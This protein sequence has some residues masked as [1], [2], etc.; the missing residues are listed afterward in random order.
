MIHAPCH[1]TASLL[2]NLYRK[3]VSVYHIYLSQYLRV[4][5]FRIRIYEDFYVHYSIAVE[6]FRVPVFPTR[7]FRLP[8]QGTGQRHQKATFARVQGEAPAPH[9]VRQHADSLVD[10]AKNGF[11]HRCQTAQ[12]LP[13]TDFPEHS[14]SIPAEDGSTDWEPS[15]VWCWEDNLIVLGK[16]QLLAKKVLRHDFLLTAVQ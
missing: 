6:P 4:C 11:L 13:D 15:L 5:V 3:L 14:P 1:S 9:N 7:Q 12:Q 2:S 16:R 8:R 10:Q